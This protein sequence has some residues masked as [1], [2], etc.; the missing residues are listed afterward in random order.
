MP[1][2]WWQCSLDPAHRLANFEEARGLPL[3]LF[4]YGLAAT[5]W[6]Q[7]QLVVPCRICEQGAMCITYDFP[8]DENRAQVA[9][10]C[11]VGLTGN[12]PGY[13]PMMWE[14]VGK[15]DSGP[16]PERVYDFKYVG[17]SASKGLQSYGLS[18][19]AVFSREELAE[20]FTLCCKVTGRTRFP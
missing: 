16:W 14:G 8:R 12:R 19:P 7:S 13:L 17:W 6:D 5:E 2:Y 11:I 4:M 18:K 3:V 9:V 15:D 1:G 20:L 10:H